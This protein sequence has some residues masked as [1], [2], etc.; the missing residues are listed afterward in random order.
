MKKVFAQGKGYV[1]VL[2]GID[3]SVVASTFTV[4]I[5]ASGSGKSTLLNLM[6]GL[7]SPTSGSILLQGQELSSLTAQELSMIRRRRI[8][9]VFQFFNLLPN[10]L[11]WQNI[12]LPLLLDGILPEAAHR[13]VSLLAEKLNINSQLETPARLLSGGEMQRVAIARAL[14]REPELIL[15]DEPTGNL[16]S[17]SGHAVLSLL[18]EVVDRDRQTIIMVTH[19]SS[20]IALADRWLTL[21][22]GTL[23]SVS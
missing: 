8:G 1:T 21:I 17:G 5:G 12:A 14:I 4:I 23:R 10:M 16:D 7:D 6:G 3:L 18:R 13:K 9:F 19:D 20:A 2:G 11:A 15:A 22:D